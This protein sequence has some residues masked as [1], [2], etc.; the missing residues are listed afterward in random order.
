MLVLS[1]LVLPR[2]ENV[3]RASLPEAEI[4]YVELNAVNAEPLAHG[5]SRRATRRVD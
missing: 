3:L 2:L 4:Q 1:Y 5:L